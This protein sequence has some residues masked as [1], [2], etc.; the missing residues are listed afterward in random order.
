MEQGKTKFA[1]E[2]SFL[3]LTKHCVK[4]IGTDTKYKFEVFMI[5]KLRMI[6]IQEKRQLNTANQ[7]SKYE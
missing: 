5:A 2:Y 1:E 6:E 7:S 3:S 4:V